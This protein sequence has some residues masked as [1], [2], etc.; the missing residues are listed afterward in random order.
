M[1]RV[2]ISCKDIAEELV[3]AHANAPNSSDVREKRKICALSD[4]K[5]PASQKNKRD[6]KRSKNDAVSN[7]DSISEVTETIEVSER[8]IKESPPKNQMERE[9]WKECIDDKPLEDFNIDT[10]NENKVNVKSEDFKENAKKH[11]GTPGSATRKR[12]V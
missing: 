4:D 10:H 8:S 1:A 5:H 7:K 2:D 12:C 3:I 6:N 9:I 11:N